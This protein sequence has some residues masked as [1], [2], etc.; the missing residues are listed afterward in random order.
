MDKNKKKIL[1]KRTLAIFAILQLVVVIICFSSTTLAWLSDSVGNDTNVI[2]A[3][4]FDIGVAYNNQ[5]ADKQLKQIDGKNEYGYLV[6]LANTGVYE[7]SI[8]IKEGSNARNGYCK[9]I[10]SRDNTNSQTFYKHLVSNGITNSVLTFTIT[11]TESDVELLF[12]P[13]CGIP[14]S[15]SFENIESEFDIN[16]L[17]IVFADSFND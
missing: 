12:V 8:S 2:S 11:T 10:A 3:S 17:D 4:T 1:S 5:I 9:I 16:N 15:N 7:I 14:V 13:G 6:T